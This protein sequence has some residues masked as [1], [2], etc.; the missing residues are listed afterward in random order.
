MKAGGEM[1]IRGGARGGE[2]ARRV[3][4]C[5]GGEGQWGDG[6]TVGGGGGEKRRGKVVKQCEGGVAGRRGRGEEE[7]NG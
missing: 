4:E 5:E 2:K 1:G 3:K 6:D 7:E